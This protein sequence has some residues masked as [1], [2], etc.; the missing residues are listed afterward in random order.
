[1]FPNYTAI[2][3]QTLKVNIFEDRNIKNKK[4]KKPS[5]L[6]FPFVKIYFICQ[7]TISLTADTSCKSSSFKGRE[8]QTSAAYCFCSKTKIFSSDTSLNVLDYSTYLI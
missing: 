1:M 6:S 7:Q 5:G 3:F 2:N 4:I 8:I